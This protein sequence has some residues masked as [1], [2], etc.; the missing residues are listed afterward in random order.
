M[1]YLGTLTNLP[2]PRRWEIGPF[3]EPVNH[4]R[5][6]RG[7][8]VSLTEPFQGLV[9]QLDGDGGG[10]GTD[11]RW[12]LFAISLKRSARAGRAAGR[13]AGAVP[14]SGVRP[15]ARPIR[16]V[17]LS[18]DRPPRSPGQRSTPT[19]ASTRDPA[20]IPMQRSIPTW[21]DQAATAA[22]VVRAS[23]VYADRDPVRFVHSPLPSRTVS[24]AGEPVHADLRAP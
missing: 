24:A 22:D 19:S 18:A 9:S 20:P 1:S 14:R 13:P 8:R 23:D 5:P 4:T 2:R 6:Q 7:P 21:C 16:T 10:A 3:Q 12:K 17:H 15:S 11:Q